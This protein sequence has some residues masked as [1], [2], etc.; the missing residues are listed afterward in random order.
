MSAEAG[1][2]GGGLSPPPRVLL[3]MPAQWPRALLRAELE[4]RGYDAIGA[5]DVGFALRYRAA[6]PGRGPVRLIVV[7]QDALGGDA[8][9]LLEGL[10]LRHGQPP[11]LLLAH[12]ARP[13]PPGAWSRVLRRPL[14]LGELADAAEEM[15]AGGS[16]K[17]G[18]CPVPPQAL[19]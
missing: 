8:H 15:V 3:V 12:A 13:T 19:R 6:E 2:E 14:R 16:L 17:R 9:L 7:D 1:E 4:E 11:L 18:P 5:P 10:A